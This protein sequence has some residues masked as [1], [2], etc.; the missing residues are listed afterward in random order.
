MVEVKRIF[1]NILGKFFSHP[2]CA[3][4]V[5]QSNF[6]TSLFDAMCFGKRNSGYPFSANSRK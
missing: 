5:F 6:S 4:L 1:R 2:K 3:K